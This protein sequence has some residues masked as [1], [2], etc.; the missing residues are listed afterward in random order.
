VPTTVLVEFFFRGASPAVPVVVVPTRRLSARGR[1]DTALAA[2]GRADNALAAE[3]RADTALTCTGN[4]TMPI[5]KQQSLWRGEAGTLTLTYD[6]GAD[7]SGWAHLCRVMDAA[8]RVLIAK[9]TAGGG[10]AAGASADKQVA[11]F[12]GGAGGD[13]DLDPAT[14][15]T[16][17]AWNWWR[18]D[19]PALLAY[20]TFTLKGAD[21]PPP[22]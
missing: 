14:D 2:R 20:G 1:D 8:G 10:I 5:E 18:T 3:G 19:S 11:T 17:A 13:T 6:G 15:G 7:I 21:L 16:P 4:F 9:T 22:V 12:T